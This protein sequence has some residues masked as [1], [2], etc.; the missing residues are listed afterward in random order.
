MLPQLTD[1]D[2]TRRE[3]RWT[4]R[5]QRCAHQWFTTN[6]ARASTCPQCGEPF[7]HSFERHLLVEIA[8]DGTETTL[9][10]PQRT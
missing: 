1:T 10:E 9:C 2:R 4:W 3:W 8:A 7:T 6:G 5:C